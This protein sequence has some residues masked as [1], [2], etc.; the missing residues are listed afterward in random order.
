M[1]DEQAADTSERRLNIQKLYLKD[2]SFES[3]AAPG[4]FSADSDWQ[5]QV[6][7]QLNTETQPVGEDVYEVAL[8]VT[9]TASEGERTAFL[10]E[11]KQ[12]GLFEIAGFGDEEHARILGAYC[13]GV[14]YPFAREVV[15]DLVQKGGLPQLVLQPINFDAV[16]A[17]NRA[18]DAD[19]VATADHLQ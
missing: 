6:N 15:A 13:P 5:P 16:Y 14:L 9:I 11:I 8:S 3:P 19:T 4:L 7:L 2:V 10:V 17:R 18:G 12:A 1:T